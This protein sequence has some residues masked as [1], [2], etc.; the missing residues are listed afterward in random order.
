MA[1][2]GEGVY[3]LDYGA[4]NVRSIRNAI[5]A[6]GVTVNTI[7]SAEDFKIAKKTHLPGRRRVRGVHGPPEGTGL[8]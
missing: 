3:L 4:G 8:R 5:A 1:A 7:E 6:V 2:A